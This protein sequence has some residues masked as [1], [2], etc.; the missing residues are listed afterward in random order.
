MSASKH[1]TDW[2][3]LL[4]H[5]GKEEVRR[6]LFAGLEAA[7]SDSPAPPI[8]E[9]PRVDITSALARFALA[10]PDAKVWDSHDLVLLKPTAARALM[11]KK[12]YSEW[13]DHPERRTVSQADVQHA[14]APPK[15]GSGGLY[16]AL[17]RY[18]YLTPSSDA[19]DT[20][21]REIVPLSVLKFTIA[22]CFDDWLKHPDRREV[23]KENL[24]FDPKQRSGQ[25]SINLFRGL[26]LKPVKS[27]D[28]C[29]AI[30]AV[31]WHLCNQDSEVFE[32]L[33]RWLAYP[34]RNVGSKMATAVLVHSETEGTGKSLLFDGVMRKIYGEYGATLGQH[35]LESQYT[36]WRSRVLFALF[37]EVLSRDQKYSHTGTLKHMITGETHRIEK[38]FVSGWEEANH[39]NCVFLS[40]EIQP[41]PLGPTDRRMLVIWPNTTLPAEVQADAVRELNGD[42]PAAFMEWLMSYPLGDFGPHTKPPMNAAKQ[43]L[44]DFGRPSWDLFVT[45]WRDGRLEWPFMTCL[46][47]DAF[48][49][50]KQWCSK[51]GERM[52]SF[53]KFSNLVSTRIPRKRD[54]HYGMGSKGTFFM[55]SEKPDDVSQERFLSDCAQKFAKSVEKHHDNH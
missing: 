54:V 48:E 41:F 8:P 42:G 22:D 11:G 40:N 2:N 31:V 17:E 4:V 47:S 28:S 13:V 38:K 30:R 27:A 49:A 37:E 19:W 21:R 1:F 3:D 34:I 43:R 29:R 14:A 44:I 26:P 25:D 20:Q 32:W 23:P 53:Y 33:M 7:N 51:T 15:W 12:L 18:V 5:A 55:V 16:A 39:M 9:Q 36:D 52:L 6:Q 50:Y 46:V 24:V 45:D 10:M 35:Q